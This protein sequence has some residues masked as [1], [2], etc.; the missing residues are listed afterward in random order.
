MS[1]PFTFGEAGC[2][3]Q[4]LLLALS[5]DFRFYYQE[6]PLKLSLNGAPGT[7]VLSGTDIDLFLSLSESTSETLKEVYNKLFECL[8]SAGYSPKRQNV[9]P[10]IKVP[11]GLKPRSL[12]P[13][14]ARL[15]AVP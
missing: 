2:P 1:A 5:G 11:S 4:G 7:A 13:W 10:N 3:I 14:T 6:S 12:R 9:S 8:T 15:E